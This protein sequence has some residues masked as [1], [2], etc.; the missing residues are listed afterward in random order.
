MLIVNKRFRDSNFIMAIKST[1]CAV[2]M[3]YYDSNK[4]ARE[5]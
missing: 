5:M 2:T 4:H 3:P 1:N